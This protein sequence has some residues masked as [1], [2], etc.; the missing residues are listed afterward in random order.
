[1]VKCLVCDKEIIGKPIERIVSS[2]YGNSGTINPKVNEEKRFFCCNE[3]YYA[4]QIL[5]DLP[6]FGGNLRATVTHLIEEH[7][8]KIEILEKVLNSGE[9]RSMWNEMGL[10]PYWRDKKK[11]TKKP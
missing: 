2:A 9:F 3:H 8:C 7:E 6:F 10:S 11:L 4:D 1:M 5:F